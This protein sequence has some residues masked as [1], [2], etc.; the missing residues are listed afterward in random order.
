MNF[1]QQADPYDLSMCWP[2]Y[3]DE[4]RNIVRDIRSYVETIKA[5][6]KSLAEQFDQRLRDLIQEHRNG[7]ACPNISQQD[8]NYTYDTEGLLN[9]VKMAAEKSALQAKINAAK[10]SAKPVAKIDA[11]T[12]AK[13]AATRPPLSLVYKGS[14]PRTH[15]KATDAMGDFCKPCAPGQMFHNGKCQAKPKPCPCNFKRAGDPDFGACPPVPSSCG[16]P[17]QHAKCNVAGHGI[18]NFV[19]RCG[20]WQCPTNKELLIEKFKREGKPIPPGLEGY[21]EFKYKKPLLG[22]AILGITLAVYFLYIK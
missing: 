15:F 11:K 17:P 14:C 5:S 16:P 7:N 3:I 1:G 2:Q 10:A 13:P 9:Q 8:A 18:K 20:K 12:A 4:A 19:C 21:G 22:L 6:D